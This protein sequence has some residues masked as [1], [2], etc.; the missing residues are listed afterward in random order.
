MGNSRKNQRFQKSFNKNIPNQNFGRKVKKENKNKVQLG[1]D[2]Q[3]LAQVAGLPKKSQY[4]SEIPVAEPRVI[5]EPVP[6]CALCGQP[7][8]NISQALMTSDGDN[9]HFDCVLEKFKDEYKP[10]E[11]QKV[12][13]IGS[14][15]FGLC[16]LNEEGKW[17]I[18]EQIQF[19]SP[20]VHKKMIEYVESLKSV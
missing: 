18:I 2:F 9:V 13:Y 5:N 14:G 12:S 3:T 16:E 4:H 8:Q 17:T 11:N 20:E 15:K 6:L 10:K 7:I 19:E 1:S